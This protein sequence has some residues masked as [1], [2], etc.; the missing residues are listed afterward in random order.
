MRR[1]TSECPRPPLAKEVLCQ[2]H[3]SGQRVLY[4]HQA[5]RTVAAD[6]SDFFAEVNLSVIDIAD[7]HLC[8]RPL[9]LD[10]DGP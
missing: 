6:L 5:G 1:A 2:R 8:R 3:T 10:H 7:A 9:S 4:R